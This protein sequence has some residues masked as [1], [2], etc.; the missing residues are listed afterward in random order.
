MIAYV[1]VETRGEQHVFEVQG[2]LG[3]L[4]PEAVRVEL[5]ADG[6]NGDSAHRQEMCSVRQL[7]GSVGGHVYRRVGAC[8]PLSNRLYGARNPVLR[9]YCCSPGRGSYPMAAMMRFRKVKE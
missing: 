8:D 2:Y 7:A 5:Y 4:D 6:L 1:K 3:D 9:W